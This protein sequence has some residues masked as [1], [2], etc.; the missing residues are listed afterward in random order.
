MKQKKKRKTKKNL[1]HIYICQLHVLVHG[2]KS[3]LRPSSWTPLLKDFV[4]LTVRFQLTWGTLVWKLS[5]KMRSRT[6]VT[7]KALQL[8]NSKK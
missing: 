6:P 3:G 5:V 2:E 4:V 1:V 7:T 8:T